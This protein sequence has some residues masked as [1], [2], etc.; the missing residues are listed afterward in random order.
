MT[1]FRCYCCGIVLGETFM[2]VSMREETDRVFL[3]S[4]SHARRI[5]DAV[6]LVTVT[7][8]TKEARCAST[9]TRKK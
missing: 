6:K 9:S 8:S 2:L 5:A 7:I 4:P 3:L 1:N